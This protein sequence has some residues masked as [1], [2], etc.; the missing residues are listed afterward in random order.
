MYIKTYEY[1][2]LL[3]KT[4]RFIVLKQTFGDKVSNTGALY[5]FLVHMTSLN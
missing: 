1:T 5:A 4:T 2:P 3:Q